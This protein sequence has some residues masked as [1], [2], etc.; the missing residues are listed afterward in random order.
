MERHER[1]LDKKA[2]LIEATEAVFSRRGYVQA[3]LDEIIDLA[4]TGKGTLYKYFGN[5]DNLFYTLVSLK[6]KELMERMWPLAEDTSIDIETRFVKILTV[7]I[8]FLWDHTVLWQ[9]LIF[10]MTGTNR[11]FFALQDKKKNLRLAAQWG[12]LP[13]EP[14]QEAILRYHRLL[15]E[16]TGPIVRV[17]R[18]GVE[19]NFFRETGKHMDIP[20]NIFFAVSM[21]VFFHRGNHMETPLTAEELARNIVSHQLYGLA[22]DPSYSC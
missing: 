20:E 14:E 13:S 1:E 8:Q 2:R 3:T 5:K 18:E 16:E 11:G 21:I 22:A 15:R 4:D 9:V 7:W 19:Q 17:Y 10:E 6:H 12:D